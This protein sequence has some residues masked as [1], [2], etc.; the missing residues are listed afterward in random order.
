MQTY[1]S[2]YK[3]DPVLR[4]ESDRKALIKGLEDGIIDCIASHH[5]PKDWDAKTKEYE[6]AEAGMITQET[7][8]SMLLAAAPNISPERWSQL[9]TENPRAIFGL[10]NPTIEK[11][12]E[13]KLTVFDTNTTWKYEVSMK[14]SLGINSPLLGQELKGLVYEF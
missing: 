5:R 9:L 14:Q 10:K 1:N 8:W 4:D 7:L 12:S 2:L 6:Y 11:D 3:V 13:T